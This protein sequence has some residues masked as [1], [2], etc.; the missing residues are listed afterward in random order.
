MM[1]CLSLWEALFWGLI[2]GLLAAVIEAGWGCWKAG[3]REQRR[4]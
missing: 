1:G 2:G 4:D 3:R